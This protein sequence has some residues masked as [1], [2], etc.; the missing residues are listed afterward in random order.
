M[1]M[2]KDGKLTLTTKFFLDDLKQQMQTK[3]RLKD[4]DFSTLES[5]GTVALQTY[6]NNNLLVMQEEIKMVFRI[7]TIEKAEDNLVLLVISSVNLKKQQ[8]FIMINSLFFDV[9]PNQINS[10]RYKKSE[11]RF[12]L[13]E[14]SY[15][16]D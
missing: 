14:K 5:N 9:F 8:P 7:E 13:R 4:A 1:T 2:A 10:V 16:Y 15:G 12:R 3:Y 6:M 11:T